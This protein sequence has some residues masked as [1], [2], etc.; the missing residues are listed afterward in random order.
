[1]S[2]KYCL[3]RSFID[4]YIVKKNPIRIYP[5]ETTETRKGEST[6]HPSAAQPKGVSLGV[7]QNKAAASGPSG[8][9]VRGHTHAYQMGALDGA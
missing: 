2:T 9:R 8:D 6:T 7:W 1:M 3:A 4:I 5:L